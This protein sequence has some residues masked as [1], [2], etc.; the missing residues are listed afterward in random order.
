[1]S[2]STQ[3]KELKNKLR[4]LEDTHTKSQLSYEKD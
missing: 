3:I 1:M 2:L 4:T